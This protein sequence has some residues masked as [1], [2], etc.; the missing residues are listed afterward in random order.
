MTVT[1]D[2]TVGHVD[3]VRVGHW[4]DLAAGTG[5][6]VVIPPPGTVGGAD[7]RGGGPST[8]EFE[9]LSPLAG[10]AGPTAVLLTGGSAHGLA[11]ADGVSGW[12]EEHGLGHEVPGIARVPIVTAAVIFDLGIAAA[13][14]RPGPAEGREACAAARPGPHARGSVGAGTGATLGKLLRGAGWCK[15][16]IGAAGVVTSDGTT[17]AAIAVANCF[18]DVLDRDGT[19][20]AGCWFPGEGMTGT[21]ARMLAD[22]PDDPRLAVGGHTTLGVV[23]TDA[24]LDPAG[25]SAV[26]RMAS[27]GLAR[28]VSP[29]GTPVDGDAVVC[30]ATGAR[31][32]NRMIIGVAAAEVL[33]E[34]VRDAVRTA[35]SLRGVPTAAERAATDS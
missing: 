18:G 19:I 28:A 34:A 10:P 8:R 3:G 4:T 29:V 26:A 21:A 20:L 32:G 24:V 14:R 12:C 17:V 6:T 35:T 27:T 31:P 23:V 22:P 16:G 25:A 15:G 9:L 1:T 33:A 2:I 5:C 13:G 7:V 30:L 11:A